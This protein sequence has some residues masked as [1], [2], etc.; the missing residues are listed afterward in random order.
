VLL[1][2]HLEQLQLK[3]WFQRRSQGLK[4]LQLLKQGLQQQQVQCQSQ[5]LLVLFCVP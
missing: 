4:E 1:V 2:V 5:L 3:V